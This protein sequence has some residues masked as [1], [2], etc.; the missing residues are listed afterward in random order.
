MPRGKLTWLAAVLLVLL[1]G[2]DAGPVVRAAVGPPPAQR[3]SAAL[4]ARL[5]GGLHDLD[6]EVRRKA[7]EALQTFRPIPPAQKEVIAALL[8]ATRDEDS[9]VQRAALGALKVI[10]PGAQE[11]TAQLLS[12]LRSPSAEVRG[13]AASDLGTCAAGYAAP[14]VLARILDNLVTVFQNDADP[15]VRSAAVR[16]LGLIGPPAQKTIPILLKALS[17]TEQKDPGVRQETAVALGQLAAD[18]ADSARPAGALVKTQKKKV[19]AALVKAFREDPEPEVQ[20]AAIQ[21]VGLLGAP[22]RAAIDPL[23]QSLQEGPS[24]VRQEAARAL[25]QLGP[26][27]EAAVQKRII[28]AFIALLSSKQTP[29]VLIAASEAVRNHVAE[30]WR[31]TGALTRLLAA[32]NPTAVRTSAVETLAEIGSSAKP[33]VPHLQRILANGREDRDLRA[34]AALAL[35]RIGPDAGEAAQELIAALQH[36][37]AQIQAPAAR[38]IGLIGLQQPEAVAALVGALADHSKNVRDEAVD[39]L[40]RIGEPAVPALVEALQKPGAGRQR[41]VSKALG[42]MGADARAALRAL[43]EAV[44][45]EEIRGHAAA[46][47]AAVAAGLKSTKE[48][49]SLPSLE[50]TLKGLQKSLTALE[51]SRPPHDDPEVNALHSAIQ[52]VQGAIATLKAESRTRKGPGDLVAWWVLRAVLVL[53]VAL[54]LWLAVLAWRPG[55]LLTFSEGLDRL[56]EHSPALLQR[57]VMIRL[58]RFFALFHYRPAVLDVWVARHLDTARAR[59]ADKELFRATYSTIPLPALAESGRDEGIETP[60]GLKPLFQTSP[61]RVVIWG[62]RHTGK[63]CWACRLGVSAMEADPAQRLGPHPMIPVVLDRRVSPGPEGDSLVELIRRELHTLV[64]ERVPLRRLFVRALLKHG[65]LLVILDGLS[66]MA[67][68]MCRLVHP[69]EP[70][71]EVNTLIVTSRDQERLDGAART[72]LA[73]RPLDDQKLDA[74]FQRSAPRTLSAPVLQEARRK[75]A[76]LLAERPVASVLLARLY[77]DVLLTAQ[78]NDPLPD[79]L[80][81][82]VLAYVRRRHARASAGQAAEEVLRDAQAVA[83]ACLRSQLRHAPLDRERVVEALR[84]IDPHN[85]EGRLGYLEG[86][87][88]I[89]RTNDP[90]GAVGFRFELVAEYLGGLHLIEWYGG[91]PHQWQAFFDRVAGERTDPV[92]NFLRAVRDCCLAGRA[93]ASLPDFVLHNMAELFTSE[94]EMTIWLRDELERARSQVDALL[95]PAEMPPVAEVAVGHRYRQATTV[96]GDFYNFIE[97]SQ[98]LAIYTVDCEGHGLAAAGQARSLYQAL[99]ACPDWGQGDPQVELAR[100][101]E[102]VSQTPI[103]QRERASF[104]MNFIEIDTQQRRV[105]CASVGMPEPLLFRARTGQV[106]SLY[107]RGVRIGRGYRLEPLDPARAAASFEDGDLLVITS[108]GILEARSPDKRL[109]ERAGLINAVWAN[110]DRSPQDIASEV[111]WAAARHASKLTPD[112]DQTVIVALLGNPSAAPTLTAHSLLQEDGDTFHLR[113]DERDTASICHDQLRPRLLARAREMGFGQ[114]KRLQE[115]WVA[116]WEAIQNAMKWG[117]EAGKVIRVCLR[118]VKERINWLRVEVSQP[119]PWGEG[120]QHLAQA[121]RAAGE[122]PLPGTAVMLRLA[123]EVEVTDRGHTVALLFAP[124]V[125]PPSPLPLEARNP[126][127]A[128]EQLPGAGRGS[129]AGVAQPTQEGPSHARK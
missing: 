53:A 2:R 19:A 99:D 112:D 98:G 58:R 67:P 24:E 82:L 115:V 77:T 9:E 122:G 26:D 46:A 57:T 42:G 15:D 38:A 30:A 75:L 63:T 70:T 87:L 103:F 7:A 64:G 71:F 94:V 78:D 100:V 117:A 23:L 56:D 128:E 123:N 43:T 96:S 81:D 12:L 28:G 65:R 108:D 40:S 10:D 11:A 111:L 54:L 13:E 97:R 16:S 125:S 83:W 45:I 47:I 68:E 22:A 95:P 118:A 29:E 6:P 102:L 17:P 106:E 127:V 62:E 90:P 107:A 113:L 50:D 61:V 105:R 69:N 104:C 109:F 36:A 74:F 39:A 33:A 73:P 124:A 1:A 31:A 89:L 27:A 35:G 85:P 48:I 3:G 20:V 25:A 126:V 120:E 44:D 5:L 66:E 86:A 72:V 110:A 8:K 49:A 101:D 92:V 37:P 21:A 121:G 114:E 34:L 4:L 32:G 116:T 41:L 129:A 55:W 60:Q 51:S 91:D 59:F 119:H 93:R 79:N 88:G 84:D 18:N 80:P 14:A 76:P 52:S